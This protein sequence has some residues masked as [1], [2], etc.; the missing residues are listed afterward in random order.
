MYVTTRVQGTFGYFDPEYTSVCCLSRYAFLFLTFHLYS[1][2]VFSLNADVIFQ[3][4]HVFI[5]YYILSDYSRFLMKLQGRKWKYIDH[6]KY[7][8]HVLHHLPY[9][10]DAITVTS[11]H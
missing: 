8:V 4:H 7:F 10:D 2:S 11:S 9:Q 5:F 1:N 3:T 6:A